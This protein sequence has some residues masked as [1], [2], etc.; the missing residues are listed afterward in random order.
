[1][2]DVNKPVARPGETLVHLHFI[3]PDTSDRS[4]WIGT[5]VTRSLRRDSAGRLILDASIDAGEAFGGEIPERPD[6]ENLL[7]ATCAPHAIVTSHSGLHWHV[8][9]PAACDR[10]PY[11]EE[12][13]FDLARELRG[14]EQ[15]PP[16]AEMFIGTPFVQHDHGDG[17]CGHECPVLIRWNAAETTAGPVPQSPAPRGFRVGD[18]VEITAR[19]D[20][21]DS[22]PPGAR[23]IG[24]TGV[25][26][27]LDDNPEFGIGLTVEG[28]LGLVWCNS[29]EVRH[30]ARL[31]PCPDCGGSGL[32]NA[33]DPV[34]PEFE[35]VDE[36][37]RCGGS[38][39]VAVESEAAR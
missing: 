33:P 27:E 9:H 34:D 26:T 13:L 2:T 12:C 11:G 23:L 19:D 39:L 6:L 32:H 3:D 30:A 29:V 24:K 5:S 18:M 37:T 1:M 16:S 4:T 15:E 14:Y 31:D 17:Q 25:V 36:C 20:E 28:W 21:D 8:T 10:L 22:T 7:D 35:S 38:G